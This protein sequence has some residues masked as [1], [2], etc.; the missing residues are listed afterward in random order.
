MH[1]DGTGP[2]GLTIEIVGMGPSTMTQ[3]EAK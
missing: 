1:F 2:D 3:A